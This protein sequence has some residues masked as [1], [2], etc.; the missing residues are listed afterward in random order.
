LDVATEAAGLMH[1]PKI[2]GQP[3]AGFFKMRAYSKGPWVPAS[4]Y[5][6]LALEP[7]TG[8]IMDRYLPMVAEKDGVS[9]PVEEVWTWGTQIEREDYEWLKATSALRTTPQK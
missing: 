5:R 7:W 8:E 6:P 2:I 3:R 4:I 9:T 1:A